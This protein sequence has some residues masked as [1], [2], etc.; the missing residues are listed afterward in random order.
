MTQGVYV[1]KD[2]FAKGK[3]N[4]GTKSGCGNVTKEGNGRRKRDRGN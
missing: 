4:K 3:R 2:L 1:I